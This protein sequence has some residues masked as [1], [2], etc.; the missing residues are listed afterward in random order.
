MSDKFPRI[1]HLPWSPGGTGDDRRMTDVVVLL[2]R[3]LVITEKLDGSNVCLTP[4]ALFARS[5]GGP[6]T[7]PSFDWLKAFH[8]RVGPSI[9][10]AFSVFCEY[11]FAVHSIEYSALPSYVWLIGVRDERSHS[12][13]SW[14]DMEQVG[15][16]LAIPVAP[17]VTRQVFSDVDQLRE[18]T[19]SAGGA[20]GCFGPREGVVVRREDGFEN[21]DFSL[22]VAKW[23]RR[24]HVVTED[25]WTQQAIRRQRLTR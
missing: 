16:Q 8:A 5:H 1:P 7:H 20:P 24:G 15:V 11:T 10:T 18:S 13:L 2:R 6:P 19:E 4:T 23:V 21:A 14:S 25:H 22:A 3:P 9:P 17:V 12:W